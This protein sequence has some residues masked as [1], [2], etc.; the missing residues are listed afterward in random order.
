MT[1]TGVRTLN[2]VPCLRRVTWARPLPDQDSVRQNLA[3]RTRFEPK[4]A[5]V[6][7]GQ[8]AI[9]LRSAGK[10]ILRFQICRSGRSHF[11]SGQPHKALLGHDRRDASGSENDHKCPNG[12]KPYHLLLSVHVRPSAPGKPPLQGFAR[13]NF[14]VP[15]I[16]P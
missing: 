13:R 10:R 15:F 11:R 9:S 8:Q 16:L 5:A 1:E 14:I 3:L 12:Q 4:G 7:V 6:G 2:V